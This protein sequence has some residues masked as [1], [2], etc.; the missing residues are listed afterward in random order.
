MRDYGKIYSQF[1]TD[2]ELQNLPD[3]PRLLAAYLLSSP[4]TNMIGCFRL[5]AAYAICDLHWNTTKFDSATHE[6]NQIG[7]LSYD[8]RSQ[9]LVIHHFLKWNRL[10]NPNQAKA[11]VKLLQTVPP[12]I[13]RE[14]LITGL[15]DFGCYLT[16]TLRSQIFSLSARNAA[17]SN[18]PENRSGNQAISQSKNR[19]AN[20]S[21]L[22]ASPS[23]PNPPANE[24]QNASANFTQPL[25][26]ALETVTQSSTEPTEDSLETVHETRGLHLAPFPETL[27]Q[28]SRNQE[29]E[30]EQEPEQEPEPKP[31]SPNELALQPSVEKTPTLPVIRRL[32]GYYL[33]AT[34][35]NP[36]TYTLTPIRLNKARA[37]W[38]D[39]MQLARSNLAD[40][41]TLMRAAIDELTSSDFHMGRDPKTAGK[42]YCD[43][44]THLFGSTERFQRWIE[45]AQQN[46]NE[47]HLHDGMHG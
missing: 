39:A 28:P 24:F 32:F 36:A 44:E 4:H 23:A 27:H 38:Q 9:W 30:Q 17:P 33:H 2:P 14:R 1:W 8:P 31:F 19:S 10:E 46:P 42:R 26:N 22:S 11:A 21:N 13:I 5:P 6:L 35:R 25:P 18:D 45:L 12:G 3:A 15:L 43:W 40:A 34:D 16:E 7:F 29:Q 47:R 37:R 41:E 20:G